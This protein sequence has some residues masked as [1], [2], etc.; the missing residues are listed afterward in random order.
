MEKLVAGA[1]KVKPG[2]GLDKDSRMGPMHTETQPAEVE[3]QLKDAVDRGAK[4]VYGG[5][6]PK[7]AEHD[8]GWVIEPTILENVPD[9][10]RTWTEDV[11]GP[12][13]PVRQ[14]KDLDEGLVL[15][16]NSQ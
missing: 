11:F 4:V 12:A 15:T 16:N 10:T 8:K 6:R 9:A 13:L 3:A 5:G 14:I 7:G 2:N 1:A